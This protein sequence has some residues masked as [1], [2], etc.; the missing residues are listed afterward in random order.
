M[1]RPRWRIG[2]DNALYD[3]HQDI[4]RKL[5]CEIQGVASGEE[6]LKLLETWIPDIILMDHMM[7][8]LSGVETT[9]RIK[10]LPEFDHIPIIMVT[11]K[12]EVQTL[13]KAFE[14]GAV[15]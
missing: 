5:K 2:V 3:T 13:K 12:N 1:A 6:A 4:L 10:Q 9:A 8:G 7:P 11:A 15:D 14:A